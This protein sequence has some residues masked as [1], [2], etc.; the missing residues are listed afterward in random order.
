MNIKKIYT[1][2]E[3]A[4]Q[5][6]LKCDIEID[7]LLKKIDQA[8]G[9]LNKI[10]KKSK[11]VKELKSFAEYCLLHPEQRFWQA[12]RNWS[13]VATIYWSVYNDKIDDL[14]LIDTYNK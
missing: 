11:S 3:K 8:D 14:E 9:A 10:T 6:L 7:E 4:Y 13:E 1:K 5:T 12:L 2:R